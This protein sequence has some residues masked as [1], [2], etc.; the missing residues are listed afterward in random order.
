MAEPDQYPVRTPAQEANRDARTG[1]V[2]PVVHREHQA[3]GW[4]Y[5][6]KLTAI[7]VCIAVTATDLEVHLSARCE[8]LIQCLRAR[9]GL[10]R[11]TVAHVNCSLDL[12]SVPHGS[13]L[14]V[15]RVSC[16]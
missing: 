16:R 11:T 2:A 8:P 7:P 9:H 14:S 13:A 4:D 6:Q 5:L 15:V 10:K 1:T 12:A 3:V